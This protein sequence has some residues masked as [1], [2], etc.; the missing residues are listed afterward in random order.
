M[1]EGWYP[2]GSWEVQQQ[3]EPR[4]GSVIMAP[5]PYV[6]EGRFEV[7]RRG[8]VYSATAAAASTPAAA[9]GRGE[10]RGRCNQKRGETC[11]HISRED[12]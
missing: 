8:R 5:S 4:D 9:G 1:Q 11:L 2:C 6:A 10:S 7:A 12:A 3:L